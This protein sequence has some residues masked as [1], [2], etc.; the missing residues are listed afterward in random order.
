MLHQRNYL[1]TTEVVEE[2]SQFHYNDFIILI[3][4]D[5]YYNDSKPPKST[6]SSNN[7]FDT[8]VLINRLPMFKIKQ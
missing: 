6:F 3:T 5:A 4:S 1:Y 8:I 7:I 2:L